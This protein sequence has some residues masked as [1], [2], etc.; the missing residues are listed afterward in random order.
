MARDLFGNKITQEIYGN[1]LKKENKREPIFKSQKNEVLA[2]QKNK[3]NGCHK[4][5]DMRATHFDHIKEV[6]K[7]GKSKVDN[8][9]ALCVSCH[10]IKTHEDKL[11]KV[12]KRR[13]SANKN[14]NYEINIITGKRKIKQSYYIDPL[15]G[16]KQKANSWGF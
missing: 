15:T 10:S 16:K 7:G 2:R 12:E 4:P 13:N 11:K 14:S 8:L 5:L 1:P 3:C 6:Y 9:Q